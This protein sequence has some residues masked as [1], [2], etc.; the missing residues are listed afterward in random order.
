M[1]IWEVFI[2]RVASLGVYRVV[3]IQH[4]SLC[5][6]WYIP[7]MPP[8][9]RIG[10][11]RRVLCPFSHGGCTTRRVLCLFSHDGGCTTRRVLCLFLHERAIGRCL[12]APSSRKRKS[13]MWWESGIPCIPLGVYW[14]P[15]YPGYIGR[16]H[17][18]GCTSLPTSR[19]TSRLHS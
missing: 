5:V 18:P 16:V 10:T 13:W 15:Y 6:G 2:P 3:Y 17:S 8:C 14:Q 9:V 4:A 12:E 19:L 1:C 11:T 7:S